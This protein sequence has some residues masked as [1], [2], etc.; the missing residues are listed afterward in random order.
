M[1]IPIDHYGREIELEYEG[2][3]Y[4]VRDNGA[5]YRK[6]RSDRRKS[7]L[8][9][10]WTFGVP[11]QRD[12]YMCIG[13]AKVHRIVAIAF[14]GHPPSQKHVVDH[15]DRDRTNN[16]I[17]NL[18]W[19]TNLENL[20]RH[21]RVRKTI[22]NA[23]G[24]LYKYF[25]DPSKPANE[26]DPSFAWLK[27][28][29]KEEAQKSRDQLQEW[30]ESDGFV[31]NGVLSNRVHG[32]RQQ[33]SP[34]RPPLPIPEKQSL[35]PMAVQ[36]RWNT[37]TEFPCCPKDIGQNPLEEYSRNLN[38]DVVFSRNR[39]SEYLVVIAELGDSFLSVISNE[40][41]ATKPWAVAKIT[42]ENEKFVHESI[43]TYFDLNG[44]KKAH[45]RL[46]GIPFNGES[47]DDY[48]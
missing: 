9:E 28:V 23:Y 18:R 1:T 6:H 17:E 34:T 39:F 33:L 12:R 19:I 14:L 45:Y 3:I 29:S 25:E 44:A 46:L 4:L 36:R 8:D 41:N 31:T 11:N 2:V 30:T 26:L 38:T 48:C 7:S 35:T 43:G 5:V 32:N 10:I 15:I 21:P 27:F 42:V 22:I 37:P 40:K 20:I 47:F 24:S 16:R 13:S